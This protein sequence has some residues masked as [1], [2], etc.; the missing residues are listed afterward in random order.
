MQAVW[1]ELS[2]ITK[3]GSFVRTITKRCNV[4]ESVSLRMLSG[5][6]MMASWLR[7]GNLQRWQ[8]DCSVWVSPGTGRKK[9]TGFFQNT[10]KTHTVQSKTMAPKIPLF[11]G[12]SIIYGTSIIAGYIYMNGRNPPADHGKVTISDAERHKA[13]ASN[14]TKYDQGKTIACALVYSMREVCVCV[15]GMPCS[16]FLWPSSLTPSAPR[17]RSGRVPHG[18]E[19]PPLVASAQCQG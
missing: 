8:V 9:H 6:S 19:P 7:N 15:V 11:L 18:P 1:M 3:W 2:K 17:D 12:G 10:H 14:A 4:C 5:C 16:V 13:F